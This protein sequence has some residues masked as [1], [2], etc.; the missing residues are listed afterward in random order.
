MEWIQHLETRQFPKK[1]AS[2]PLTLW[3]FSLT[4]QSS[5][6]NHQL[7]QFLLLQPLDTHPGA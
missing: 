1:A 5:N 3:S 2:L 4:D 6:K 7:L